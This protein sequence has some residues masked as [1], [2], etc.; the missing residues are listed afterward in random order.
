MIMQNIKLCV[1]VVPTELYLV[2]PLPFP[3]TMTTFE[4][5]SIIKTVV[6]K[7]QLYISWNYYLIQFEFYMVG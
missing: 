6:K 1:M 7:C 3:V 5:H 4:G 2:N